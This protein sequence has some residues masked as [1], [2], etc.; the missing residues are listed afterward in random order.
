MSCPNAG[1]KAGKPFLNTLPFYE[2]IPQHHGIGDPFCG[3]IGF[4]KKRNKMNKQGFNFNVNYGWWIVAATFYSSLIFSGCI[5]FAFSLFVKPLQAEFGWSRSTIMAAFSLLF[6]SLGIASPLA[7]RAVDRYGPKVVMSLGTLI[8]ALGFASLIALASPLHYY[9]SYLIIGI[10]GAAIGPVTSTAVVSGWFQEKR[11]LAIGFMSTGIGVGGLI[12]APLVGG[13]IIPKIGWRA[14]YL[15]ISLLTGTLIPLTLFVIKTKA[16]YES[17][18]R[19]ALHQDGPKGMIGQETGTNELNLRDALFSPAFV[20]IAGAFMLSQFS[21]N[22]TIQSHVPHLQ[23]IGFPVTTA[24][25]ALG[26]IGLVSAFS[27]LFFGWLC[28]KINPKYAFS[29]GVLFMSGGTFILTM[30]GPTSPM[31]VLW[32]YTLIMGIGAGSWLPAM[33]MLV[34]RNFG[35]AAYGA[36]FGAAT[37]A[38]NIGVSTGPLFAGYVYDITRNYHWAF[39][40]FMLFYF[41]SIPAMLA[42]KRPGSSG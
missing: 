12:L 14:G 35:L 34:S 40:L 37:L 25:V 7:G 26:G 3:F 33:S 8:T 29:I 1:K 36:I 19:I 17:D 31:L 5:Y 2:F 38:H 22:G 21:I 4:F 11:G 27:K 18:I 16:A 39:M 20:F 24:S 15:C 10:G 23:D 6:I 13:L 30:I 9:I 42:L 28:D 41:C 32:S